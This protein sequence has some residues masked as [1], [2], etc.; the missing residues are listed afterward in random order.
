MV[1]DMTGTAR[2]LIKKKAFFA[3][4]Q[5]STDQ[6]D[7]LDYMDEDEIN[8]ILVTHMPIVKLAPG[9]YMLGTKKNT[10]KSSLMDS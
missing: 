4:N 8:E 5:G 6:L 3:Q 7:Y 10:F 9:E 2:N 1:G